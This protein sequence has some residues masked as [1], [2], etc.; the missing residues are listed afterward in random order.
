[1]VCVPRKSGS[2]FGECSFFYIFSFFAFNVLSQLF[3]S[4]IST[5]LR[6]CDDSFFYLSFTNIS[7]LNMI[8]IEAAIVA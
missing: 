1:M 6:I 8:V 5:Y 2:T 3:S 4:F 7:F